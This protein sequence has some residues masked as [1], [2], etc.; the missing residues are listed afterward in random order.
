M[1]ENVSVSLN[2]ISHSVW[3]Y[4]ANAGIS[5]A[6]APSGRWGTGKCVEPVLPPEGSVFTGTGSPGHPT[7][8]AWRMY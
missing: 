1:I 2:Y 7:F 4:K 6:P 3:P 5:A 8:P